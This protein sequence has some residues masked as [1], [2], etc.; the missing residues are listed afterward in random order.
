MVREGGWALVRKFHTPVC[1][2]E[3]E[4]RGRGDPAVDRLT[5]LSVVEGLDGLLR[6]CAPRDDK[7]GFIDFIPQRLGVR[8]SSRNDMRG[9]KKTVLGAFTMECE[10]SGLSD[11]RGTD[12]LLA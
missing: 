3:R 11:K 9:W 7:D 10:I 8:H 6:R 5:A 1:H 2:R 4:E 12:A